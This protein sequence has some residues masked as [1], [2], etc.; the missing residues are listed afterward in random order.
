MSVKFDPTINTGNIIALLIMLGGLLAI[1][2]KIETTMAV[3]E[4]KIVNLE[5]NTRE[6]KEELIWMRRN[7]LF[8]NYQSGGSPALEPSWVD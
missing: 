4:T 1:Y 2:V 5:E 7:S 3:Y 6:I 8:Q